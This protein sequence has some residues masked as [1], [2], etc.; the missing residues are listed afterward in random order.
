MLGAGRCLFILGQYW[1]NVGAVGL[2]VGLSYI[3]DVG[4]VR[5]GVGL[6]LFRGGARYVTGG[7]T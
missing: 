2:E 4:Y 1:F 5:L 3:G 7:A 6:G